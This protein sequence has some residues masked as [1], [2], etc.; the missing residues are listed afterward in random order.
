MLLAKAV[1]VR[2]KR[3]VRIHP[4]ADHADL[5]RGEAV[6]QQEHALADRL[7]HDPGGLPQ[8][9]QLMP[10][11]VE[12]GLSQVQQGHGN[13]GCSLLLRLARYRGGEPF[14]GDVPGEQQVGRLLA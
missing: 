10:H 6:V 2:P 14:Q 8:Q 12:S 1:S 3:R 11:R 9:I 5:V 4:R 13:P 7:G